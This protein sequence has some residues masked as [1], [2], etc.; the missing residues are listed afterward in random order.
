MGCS[1]AC[2]R[3]PPVSTTSATRS[4]TPS[5]TAFSTAPSSLTISALTPARSSSAAKTPGYEVAMRIPATCEISEGPSGGLARRK[6]EG[7]NPSAN[8]SVACAP[9]SSSMSRPVIPRSS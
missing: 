3:V 9:E 2:L 5:A 8:T 7:P 4:A 6:V 1:P